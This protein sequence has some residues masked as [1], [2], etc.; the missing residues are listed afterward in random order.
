MHGSMSMALTF[1]FG[2]STSDLFF[3]NLKIDGFFPF[4]GILTFFLGLAFLSEKI[5]FAVDNFSG[6]RYACLYGLKQFVHVLIMIG[7][8]TMNFWLIL[9]LCVGQAVGRYYIFRSSSGF[10]E[11]FN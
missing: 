9:G 2:L 7:Y 8:M 6:V 1:R 5:N 10:M 11:Q 3:D 4:L